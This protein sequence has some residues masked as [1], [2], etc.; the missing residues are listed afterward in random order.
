MSHPLYLLCTEAV[1]WPLS[2]VILAC[3][4]TGVRSFCIVMLQGSHT[5]H[6]ISVLMLEVI[7]KIRRF[8]HLQANFE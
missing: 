8:V 6:L 3:S 7:L 5:S 1:R 4:A 2:A